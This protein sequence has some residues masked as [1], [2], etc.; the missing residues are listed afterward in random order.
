MNFISYA[1][2]IF[3]NFFQKT[4]DSLPVHLAVLNEQGVIVA[5]NDAPEI[6]TPPG[7]LLKAFENQYFTLD[8]LE[9]S[10]SDVEEKIISPLARSRKTR[11]RIMRIARGGTRERLNA[12]LR[13]F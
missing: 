1:F 5:V 13:P 3:K 4:L 12:G 6:L 11:S 2:M 7:K 10:D 8:M 9:I